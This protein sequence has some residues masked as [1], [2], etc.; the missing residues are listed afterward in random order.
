[1]PCHPIHLDCSSGRNPS[2][3]T[4]LPVC[5]WNRQSAAGCNDFANGVSIYY[6]FD[7]AIVMVGIKP[8]TPRAAELG[9][10]AW[11]HDMSVHCLF[12]FNV[13]CVVWW[14]IKVERP[15]LEVALAGLEPK[16]ILAKSGGCA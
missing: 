14:L 15:F 5:S 6:F 7:Q 1:M 12:H 2:T 13:L 3:A 4:C 11:G 16:R 10:E 9:A 8:V